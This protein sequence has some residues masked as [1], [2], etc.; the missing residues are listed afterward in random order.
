MTNETDYQSKDNVTDIFAALIK[1]QSEMKG[2]EKSATNP[3]LNTTYAGLDSYISASREALAKNGLGVTQRCFRE[4]SGLVLIT[5]LIHVSGQWMSDGGVPVF[6][7]GRKGINMNQA[8][9]GA[10]SYA[11]RYAYA[12]ILG[13]AQTDDDGNSAGAP[14]NQLTP[15]SQ[16]QSPIPRQPGFGG[17]VDYGA[18]P[19]PPMVAP[20][21]GWN[22][23]PPPEAPPATTQAPGNGNVSPE[24][25]AWANTLRTQLRS[26]PHEFAI[27]QTWGNPQNIARLDEL[28][29]AS[30]A[31]YAH[32]EGEW[33]AAL[34]R[35]QNAAP[36]A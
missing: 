15:P 35:V 13:L 11:R 7:E 5:T 14:N 21:P 25:S 31:A 22:E 23:P 34:V 18:P 16:P 29:Q 33:H 24:L 9:G 36:S 32:L 17:P 26:A 20:P 19:G 28:R 30:P 6:Y 3:H 10:I 12:A 4:E 8:M 1:F 2:I 27:T